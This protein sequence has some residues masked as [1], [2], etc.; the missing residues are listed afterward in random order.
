MIVCRKPTYIRRYP[1]KNHVYIVSRQAEI[2]FTPI[3]HYQ[4][5]IPLDPTHKQRNQI[6][7]RTLNADKTP[8][9]ND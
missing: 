8:K 3:K 5:K 6:N 7:S 2:K 4:E 9:G 1:S